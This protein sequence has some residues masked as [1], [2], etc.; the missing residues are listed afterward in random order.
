M[1]R[2]R[3]YFLLEKLG[4]LHIADGVQT[5]RVNLYLGKW[6]VGEVATAWCLETKAALGC[7]EYF[8]G[9]NWCR[10]RCVSR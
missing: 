3:V 4:K 1:I 2:R 10:R 5:E 9:R 8:K 6:A 7:M